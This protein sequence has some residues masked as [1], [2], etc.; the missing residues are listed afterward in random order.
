MC[1]I[2][3]FL[4]I[5]QDFHTHYYLYKANKHT[6]VAVFFSTSFKYHKHKFKTI[7]GRLMKSV[8]G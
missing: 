7:S 5:K 3:Y 6:R 8:G 2:T 1:Y 4:S